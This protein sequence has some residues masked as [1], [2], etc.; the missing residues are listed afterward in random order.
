[1]KEVNFMFSYICIRDMTYNER[2]A[3]SYK[4]IER[5]KKTSQMPC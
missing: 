3:E 2:E 4:Y 5:E 1:M